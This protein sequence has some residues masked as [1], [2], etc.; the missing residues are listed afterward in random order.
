MHL[1]V[2]SPAHL[3]EYGQALRRGWSPNTERPEAAEEELQSIARDPEAFLA[4]LDDRDA[5]GPPIML[6]DGSVVSRLPG[7]VRW[8][9]DEDRF[10]GSIGFRWQRGTEALP[11][12]CLGHIGYS[13][14]PWER[15]RGYA[16]AALAAMLP[17]ARAEGLRWVE[18]TTDPENLFS[19]RVIE[20]NGGELV[21][22]FVK[23]QE[24]GGGIGLRYRIPL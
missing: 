1:V 4:A 14:V 6:P 8:M 10:V 19:Q 17:L 5:A 15:R 3:T 22:E 21:E 2:P 13:V 11:P 7:V 20:A 23:T 9:W 18:L 12:T 24:Y 16:T